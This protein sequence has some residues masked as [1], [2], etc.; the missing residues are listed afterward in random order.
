MEHPFG[1]IEAWMGS[2]HFL[3][4][5]LKNVRTEISLYV[6]ASNMK[7]MIATLGIKPLKAAMQ[8]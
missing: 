7:G 5:R 1:T 6:P 2:I 8:T 4:K 3:T